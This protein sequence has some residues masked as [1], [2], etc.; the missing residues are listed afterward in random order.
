MDAWDRARDGRLRCVV[1]PAA[2]MPGG[3]HKV[4]VHAPDKLD[5]NFLG[6]DG[7]A[8]AVIRAAPEEFA[9]HR[10]DHIRPFADRAAAGLAART[11]RCV[12]FAAVKSMAAAFGQAATHAPQ[13]MH[14]A[15]SNAVSADSLGTR[16]ALASG[17]PPVGTLMNPPA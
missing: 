3:A 2:G 13:P 7:F 4:A 16:I 1:L 15:A 12:I 17:A 8:L 10:R 11:L 6:A 14:A 5:G 9:F